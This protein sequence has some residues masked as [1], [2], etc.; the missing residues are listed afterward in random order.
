MSAGI[1]T[2]EFSFLSKNHELSITIYFVLVAL[3]VLFGISYLTSK[4]KPLI[5]LFKILLTYSMI[6]AVFVGLLLP[7]GQLLAYFIDNG[8]NITSWLNLYGKWA[9]IQFISGVGFALVAIASFYGL[10]RNVGT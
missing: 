1:T 10:Q 4:R 2:L 3:I 9:L 6:S 8:F 7:I 5:N